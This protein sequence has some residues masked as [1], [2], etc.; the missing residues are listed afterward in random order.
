MFRSAPRH[1]PKLGL[2][3]FK[4]L[5]HHNKVEVY[6]NLLQKEIKIEGERKILTGEAFEDGDALEA[7]EVV[8]ENIGNPEV[9]QELKADRVPGILIIR[10]K[11]SRIFMKIIV[12][13]G[14]LNTGMS[15]YLSVIN[16]T[17]ACKYLHDTLVIISR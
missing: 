16:F 6:Q 14:D 4:S 5:A 8:D 11:L 1:A 2:A 9:G 15:V 7:L 3:A 12:N 17:K 10:L 13:G